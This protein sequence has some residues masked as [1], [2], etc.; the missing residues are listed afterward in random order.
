[1]K[2]RLNI[3]S[4]A[5]IF[6]LACSA[7]A[8]PEGDAAVKIEP[9]NAIRLEI[10]KVAKAEKAKI[11][12]DYPVSAKGLINLPFVGTVK[13]EG[14]T[15]GEAEDAIEEAYKRMKIYE[16]PAIKLGIIK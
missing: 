5:L 11:D 4:A 15:I 10:Q 6:L 2:N 14:L 7:T 13:I 1:M 3:I 12:A 9:G 16:N 8:K